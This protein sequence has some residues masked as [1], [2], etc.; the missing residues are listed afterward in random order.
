MLWALAQRH[1]DMEKAREEGR[2]EGKKQ[3]RE[4]G[5]KQGREE[6]KEQVLRDLLDRGVELPPELLKE[7]GE[8]TKR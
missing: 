5:N 2:E 1:K 7:M 4:E 8:S 6:G 3:G